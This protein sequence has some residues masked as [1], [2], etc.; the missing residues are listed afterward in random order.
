MEDSQDAGAAGGVGIESVG[1]GGPSPNKMARTTR[2]M[3]RSE[4]VCFDQTETETET[5]SEAAFEPEDEDED[6]MYN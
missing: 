6:D 5:Q 1:D 2:K 3:S 4:M